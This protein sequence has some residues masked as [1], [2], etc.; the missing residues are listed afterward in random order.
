MAASYVERLKRRT[1]KKFRRAVGIRQRTFRQL[2][3]QVRGYLEQERRD[4]PLKRRG[5]KSEKLSH[6][7]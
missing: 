7:D 3:R 2:R 1:G 5:K 4:H 6:E